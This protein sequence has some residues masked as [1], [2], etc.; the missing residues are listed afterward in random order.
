MASFNLLDEPWVPV[1]TADGEPREVGLREALLRVA[2]LR[3]IS[4]PSPLVVVALHRLLLAILHRV[5]GPADVDAWEV[6]WRRG[7]FESA[8]LLAYLDRWRDRFDLFDAAWPF[9][10]VAGLGEEYAAPVARLAH[11]VAASNDNAL[12]NHTEDDASFLTP[13]KA[14]RSVVA[15]QAFAVGGLI[16]YEKGQDPKLYKSA[17]AAPLTK[18][19]VVLARGESLFQTLLLNLVQ[20]NPEADEPFAF[21]GADLPLWERSEPTRPEDRR[22]N[23]YVDLLTWPSRR[24]RLFPT[25]R[26]GQTVVERVVIMK[27]NQFPDGFERRSHET[28]VAFRKVEKPGKGQD[29]WPAMTFQAERALW[30]DSGALFQSVENRYHRPHNLEWLSTLS[31]KGAIDR[32]AT[33]PLEVLGLSVDRAKVFFWRHEHLPLPVDYLNDRDL[34]GALRR[35]LQ[36][37]DDGAWALRQ[38]SFTLANYLASPSADQKDGRKPRPED[39]QPIQDGFGIERGYWPLLDGRFR[40]LLVA[41][42]GD[43]ADEGAPLTTWRDVVRQAALDAFEDVAKSLTG[44]ARDLK[45]VAFADRRLRAMLRGP[46]PAPNRTQGG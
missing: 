45:A 15:H 30:R 42:P 6:L 18:G 19:A 36:A 22:P 40:D 44:S 25:T 33:I 3:E 38:A 9:Y 11:E 32:A 27:G 35:A 29:P 26:D 39:L 17:D 10:Q 16:T 12:F 13:A 5:Y 8:P 20:Y 1:L 24:I 41:L 2:D 14:A 43:I 4:D 23:G 7:A 28:M 21:R 46:S 37:A 31:R 34:F